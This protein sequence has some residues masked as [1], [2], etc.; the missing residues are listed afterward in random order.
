MTVFLPSVPSGR[1]RFHASLV[2][3][4]TFLHTKYVGLV[5]S[6][7]KMFEESR[8]LKKRRQESINRVLSLLGPQQ[9]LTLKVQTSV[10]FPFICPDCYPQ[11]INH[12]YLSWTAPRIG[13]EKSSET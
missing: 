6:W 1:F 5:R 13:A 8:F 7:K 4:L 10:F 11:W 12:S 9:Y 3:C 2:Q